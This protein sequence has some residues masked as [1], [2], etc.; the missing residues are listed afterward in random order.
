MRTHH[1]SV[2]F[3]AFLLRVARSLLM[4]VIAFG[5]ENWKARLKLKLQVTMIYDS[6]T[7]LN[8]CYLSMSLLMQH[9]SAVFQRWSQN[10]T[11]IFNP[12]VPILIWL[13]VFM[14]THMNGPWKVQLGLVL[15][16]NWP[17]KPNNKTVVS[18]TLYAC[19][20]SMYYCACVWGPLF[21]WCSDKKKT[22]QGASSKRA[23]GW[24]RWKGKA[25][26]QDSYN[27]RFIVWGTVAV[28]SFH[29]VK[30]FSTL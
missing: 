28:S 23:R 1:I 9:N 2:S 12:F 10:Q 25:E 7:H 21:H 14:K 13:M 8:S 5:M 29:W 4:A 15:F 16:R 11:S 20:P 19:V 30:N 17:P 18:D 24:G 26:G 3:S 22:Q 27:R 6:P